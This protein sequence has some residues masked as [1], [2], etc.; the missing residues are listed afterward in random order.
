LI[1]YNS[2]YAKDPPKSWEDLLDPKWEGKIIF[3]DITTS[4]GMGMLVLLAKLNGGSETNIDPGFEKIKELKS[5][6]LTFWTN[7]D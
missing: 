6:V 1:A 5:N 3:P 2:E 7:H 4:H